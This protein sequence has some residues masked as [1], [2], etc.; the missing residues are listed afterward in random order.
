MGVCRNDEFYVVSSADTDSSYA[1]LEPQFV[2]IYLRKNKFTEPRN[3]SVELFK[4]FTDLGGRQQLGQK[5]AG[6]H[7]TVEHGGTVTEFLI[8]A[9]HTQA[10]DRPIMLQA[11][12][13]MLD[14]QQYK[15]ARLILAMDANV[16]AG[17][18]LKFMTEAQTT[19]RLV[20][21]FTA[22][23]WTS[24]AL[25]DCWT[26]KKERT[27]MQTQLHKTGLLDIALKDY[28]FFNDPT[29]ECET[30]ILNNVD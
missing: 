27:C 6:A 30:S 15:G 5:I 22:S 20:N 23:G 17:K 1:L 7:T 28:I 11:V 2:R 4:I 12:Q 18:Q 8:L 29:P 10:K 9:L 13:D 21:S 14:L 16:A 26:T 24:E 19:Y 3:I 25:Q